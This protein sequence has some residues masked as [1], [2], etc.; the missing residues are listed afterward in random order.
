MAK[1][2]ARDRSVLLEHVNTI[3]VLPI[4]FKARAEAY[5]DLRTATIKAIKK[6]APPKDMEVLRKYGAASPDACVLFKLANGEMVKIWLTSDSRLPFKDRWRYDYDDERGLENNK[7]FKQYGK[8][9]IPPIPDAWHTSNKQHIFI[10]DTAAVDKA[11]AAYEKARDE[12]QKEFAQTKADF[13]ALIRTSTRREEIL[14]VWPGAKEIFSTIGG[15]LVAINPDVIARIKAHP[16]VNG[17][18]KK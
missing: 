8:A 14:D 10:D 4:L 18:N 1:L 6:A 11:W 15:E 5:E 3:A 12:E 7:E 16:N 17:T 2:T 9:D 13:E